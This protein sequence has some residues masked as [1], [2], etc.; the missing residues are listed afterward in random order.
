QAAGLLAYYPHAD[1]EG[2]G[3]FNYQAPVVTATRQ[4]AVRSTAS[5]RINNPNLITG[6]AS[7]QRTATNTTSLFGFEDSRDSSVFDTQASWQLTMSRYTTLRA[8]YQYT[9]TATESVPYFANRV[10]V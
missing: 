3:R 2:A 10:N 5:Y 8:R 4:D 7:F 6:A 9:R 1:L